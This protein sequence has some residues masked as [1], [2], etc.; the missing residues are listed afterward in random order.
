[1]IKEERLHSVRCQWLEGQQ[2][3][4]MLPLRNVAGKGWQHHKRGTHSLGLKSI[5]SIQ[6]LPVQVLGKHTDELVQ[7]DLL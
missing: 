4:G 2:I 3:G 7:A 6:I 1:M 5:S